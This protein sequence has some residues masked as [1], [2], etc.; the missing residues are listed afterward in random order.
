MCA[1][2]SSCDTVLKKYKTFKKHLT[3]ALARGVS[4]TPK[5]R[6]LAK[7]EPCP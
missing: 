4:W 1:I 6:Q 7:V 3:P 2:T 5:M